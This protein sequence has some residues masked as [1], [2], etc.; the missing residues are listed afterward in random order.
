M[1]LE[2]Q[3]LQQELQQLEQGQQQLEQGQQQQEA[4]GLKLQQAMAI[5]KLMLN[6][7]SYILGAHQG[8]S[9]GLN[10][11][12]LQKVWAA[13]NEAEHALAHL[14]PTQNGF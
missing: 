11:Q 4:C 10:Q 14:I 7:R 2:T 3:R 5:I 13:L 6:R 9:S 8:P 12:Q 1:Q